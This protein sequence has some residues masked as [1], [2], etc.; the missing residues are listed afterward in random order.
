MKSDVR[1]SVVTMDPRVRFKYESTGEIR[2][3]TIVCPEK[4][5]ASRGQA[6]VL[7]PVESALI[8]LAM[9]QTILWP[10]PDGSKRNLR[11][12]EPLY[13]SDAD[14]ASTCP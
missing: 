14:L 13:R 3:V 12:L 1:P 11:V 6:S 8:G 10:F 7:A 9:A 5:D 4:A 2:E